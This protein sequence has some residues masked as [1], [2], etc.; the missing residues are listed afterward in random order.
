MQDEG[1]NYRF[2]SIS[3]NGSEGW[4]VGRPAILLHTTDGGKNWER[5]PLS[6]KLPGNPVLVYAN[7]GKAGQVEMVTDQVYSS[8][9]AELPSRS[10][11]HRC[12]NSTAL[13]IVK[14]WSMNI[15]C[16]DKKMLETI[17]VPAPARCWYIHLFRSAHLFIICRTHPLQLM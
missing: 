16:S 4:I 3:F 17:L 11:T 6:A 8:T 15:S 9:S 10:Q 14:I 12:S 7:N 1:F 2:N 5:V 13:V